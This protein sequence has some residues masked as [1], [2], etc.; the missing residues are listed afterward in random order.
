MELTK[1]VSTTG[2]LILE[3]QILQK[4]Q[5]NPKNQILTI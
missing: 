3:T 4:Q 5:R 1:K 2:V